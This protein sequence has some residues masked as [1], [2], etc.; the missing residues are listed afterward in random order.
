MMKAFQNIQMDMVVRY[1]IVLPNILINIKV[2]PGFPSAAN[3]NASKRQDIPVMA[4]IYLS[5]A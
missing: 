5:I 4:S 2:F 1:A 3:V